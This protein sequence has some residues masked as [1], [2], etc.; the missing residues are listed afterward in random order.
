MSMIEC[1]GAGNIC[2]VEM[3]SQ[4]EDEELEES[5]EASSTCWYEHP[6]YNRYWR[7]HR[8]QQFP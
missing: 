2:D 7:H 6:K 8:Y 5:S 1:D 4:T 3:N